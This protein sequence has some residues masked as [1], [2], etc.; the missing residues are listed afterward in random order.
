VIFCICFSLKFAIYLYRPISNSYMSIDIFY[1]LG[2]YVPEIIPSLLQL[3]MI[4]RGV[5]KIV[6]LKQSIDDLYEISD[7]YQRETGKQWD[8]EEISILQQNIFKNYYSLSDDAFSEDAAAHIELEPS[9]PEVR[10][11]SNMLSP[12]SSAERSSRVVSYDD[13]W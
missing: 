10:S 1:A 7:A 12:P 9:T 6:R 13:D 8:E 3:W 4:S 5:R 2:Y 11:A